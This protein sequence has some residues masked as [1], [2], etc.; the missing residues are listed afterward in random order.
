MCQ[1]SQ[2]VAGLRYV[3]H[4]LFSDSVWGECEMTAPN[5]SG[6]HIESVLRRLLLLE[7]RDK[8]PG[9]LSGGRSSG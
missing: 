7:F 2:E 8:L 5:A 9:V 6:E 4:Q 1:N 3:N